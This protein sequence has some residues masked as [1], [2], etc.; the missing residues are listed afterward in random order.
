LIV[1][2]WYCFVVRTLGAGASGGGGL[3]LHATAHRVK[4][5]TRRFPMREL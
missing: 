5:S 2:G 1:R 4:A 3:P